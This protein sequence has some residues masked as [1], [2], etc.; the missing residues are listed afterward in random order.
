MRSRNYR[1]AP[2]ALPWLAL[3]ATLCATGCQWDSS[4]Y[5]AAV[6]EDGYIVPCAPSII[7][8][9]NDYILIQGKKCY[10]SDDINVNKE[11][12][13][14]PIDNTCYKDC[15]RYR[16]IWNHLLPFEAEDTEKMF[17]QSVCQDFFDPNQFISKDDYLK[18]NCN[19]PKDDDITKTL[20]HNGSLKVCPKTAPSCTYTDKNYNTLAPDLEQSDVVFFCVPECT[21]TLCGLSCVDILTDRNNCGSCGHRCG[22]GQ[23][24][25]KGICVVNECQTGQVFCGNSCIDPNTNQQYCGASLGGACTDS[26]V[27]SADYK[28]KNCL[29]IPTATLCA[30]GDCANSCPG[31]QEPCGN[32][33][34]DKQTSPQHCGACDNACPNGFAC[35]NGECSQDCATGTE[36]CTDRCLNFSD[37]HLSSCESCA[38]GYCDID[39]NFLNGCESYILGSD[40][41]NCGAC[42]N[43]C[44]SGQA[45][46]DG[47]CQTSCPGS[48]KVCNGNCVDNQTD[49]YNCGTCG[50]ICPAGQA[51]VEG[52]CTANCAEGFTLCS[53][54][55]LNLSDLHLA[56]CVAC[57]EDYCDTDSNKS[58]GCE[59]NAKGTDP[60][61]CGSC[62]TSCKSGEACVD[63]VCQTSCPGSQKVCGGNCVDLQTDNYNC[64]ACGTQCPSGKACVNGTCSTSCASGTTNC[65]GKCLNFSDL[66]LASCTTCAT[67][68]CDTDN[69][70]ANGCESNAKGTDPKNCGSCGSSCKSGEAC[71]D[72]V[73]QTSCPGRDRKSVV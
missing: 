66:H 28:G 32:V 53:G 58:N 63:G 69:N 45:C 9:E 34:V 60:K 18:I 55:C 67:N 30:Q 22:D 13:C 71:V 70:K 17:V 3:C 72:G 15:I 36:L 40:P 43:I 37:L 27:E 46:V 50:N 65:S 21:K 39:S 42:G 7:E 24:C 14:K 59:S 52:A 48:Q 41:K 1:L 20:L 8:D 61:N 11:D 68:Y 38:D 6:N 57:A 5:D 73:C 19:A 64:G 26:E 25:E 33:C 47:V 56:S 49:N 51:C 29:D 54:K 10:Q 44:P 2:R 4:V 12:T 35:V 62:G 23:P 16:T 31:T